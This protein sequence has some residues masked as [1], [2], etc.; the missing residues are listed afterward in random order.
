MTDQEQIIA[1]CS[2]IITIVILS[3]LGN[4]ALYQKGY[5]LLAETSSD[6]LMELIRAEKIEG[7]RFTNETGS[8]L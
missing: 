3:K 4:M 2:K 1:E 6:I 8:D 5:D 7:V